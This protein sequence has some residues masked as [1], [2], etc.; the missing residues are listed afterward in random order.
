MDLRFEF[1]RLLVADFA[2][3]FRFYRDVLELPVYL[4]EEA[5]PY[6]EFDTGPVRL[7][8]F[9]KQQM[10]EAIGAQD[11][12]ETVVGKDRVCLILAVADV[13][14][15]ARRLE[16]KGLSPAARPTDRPGWDIRTAH[17][18]DPEGN[19]FEINQR[20]KK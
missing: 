16:E 10:S 6:A 7:A 1:T 4:G 5:G 12:P 9:D 19:L 11:L 18:R 14:A 15:A 3:C 20:L 8:L 2:A 17:F 13:D